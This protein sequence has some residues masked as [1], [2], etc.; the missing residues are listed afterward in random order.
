MP[1]EIA[2]VSMPA[3]STDVPPS[4]HATAKKLSAVLVDMAAALPD[5]AITVR[6]LSERIG[7]RG[8]LVF[9]LFLNLPFLLPAPPGPWRAEVQVTPTFSPHELDPALGDARQLG[10]QIS[11]GYRSAG[12]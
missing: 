1:T 3:E 11:F 9:C 2:D 10:A 6:E 12:A 7:E 8:L 4:T 5:G